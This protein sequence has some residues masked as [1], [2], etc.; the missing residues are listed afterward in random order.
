MRVGLGLHAHT[1]TAGKFAIG[2]EV[3][4][5][6]LSALGEIGSKLL[7][8]GRAYVLTPTDDLADGSGQVFVG[9]YRCYC[10]WRYE[11]SPERGDT[12]ASSSIPLRS[13][14]SL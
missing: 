5:R 13:R 3:V 14:V 10:V 4:R 9:T 12:R 8:K 11:H 7:R 2:E 6:L 1:A